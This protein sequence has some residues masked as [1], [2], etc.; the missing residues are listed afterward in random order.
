MENVIDRLRSSIQSV[1]KQNRGPKN[2]SYTEDFPC[3]ISFVEANILESQK[4]V[5]K[6]VPE[7]QKFHKIK[8]FSRQHPVC[9]FLVKLCIVFLYH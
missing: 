7:V 8:N 9:N 6:D 5:L 3:H 2:L 4:D 1:R